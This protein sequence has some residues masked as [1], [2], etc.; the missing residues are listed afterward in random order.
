MVSIDEDTA[1]KLAQEKTNAA[2]APT[3][4]ER[5]SQTHLALIRHEFRLHN[6]VLQSVRED[7]KDH[8][9]DVGYWIE[10]GVAEAHCHIAPYV[11]AVFNSV[12]HAIWG[13]L[14]A[15]KKPIQDPSKRQ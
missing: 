4:W 6:Q 9:R 11:M 2:Q 14:A 7:Q 3:A 5:Y 8:G 1:E 10:R 15:C 12:P 13:V